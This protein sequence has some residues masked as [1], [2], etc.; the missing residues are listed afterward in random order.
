MTGNSTYPVLSIL[1]AILFLNACGTDGNNDS[2]ADWELTW[3]DDF[4]GSKG[5][6]LNPVNWTYDIGTSQNGWG[7]QELQYYTNRPENVSLDGEGNL[8]ITA[9]AE[10]FSGSPYTSARIKTEVLFDQAY[11]GFEA[12]IITPFGPGIWPPYWMLGADFSAAGWPHTGKIDIMKFRGQEPQRIHGTLHGPGYSA[13]TAVTS[14]HSLSNSRFDTSFHIFAV[15]WLK[16]RI[17][18]FVDEVR[19][20][21]IERSDIDGKWVFNKPFFLILNTA[22]GGTFV[23]PPTDQTPFPQEMI[24]DFVKVYSMAE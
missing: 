2:N 3:S 7:N 14:S 13:G 6:L 23:G 15:E 22:V 11:G 21:C 5:E 9:I 20:Q 12:R 4:E 18:Y 1:F 8:V 24:I 16:N 19:Y 17:D 10:P